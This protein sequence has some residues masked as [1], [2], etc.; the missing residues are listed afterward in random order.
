VE[1]VAMLDLVGVWSSALAKAL[2]VGSFEPVKLRRV[3]AGDFV[4]VGWR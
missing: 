1:A 3:R 4:D 2:W